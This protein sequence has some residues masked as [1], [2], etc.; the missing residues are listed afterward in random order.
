M[1][2]NRDAGGLSRGKS[3]KGTDGWKEH[4]ANENGTIRLGGKSYPTTLA[5]GQTQV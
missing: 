5:N 2:V 4:I 1:V 3:M